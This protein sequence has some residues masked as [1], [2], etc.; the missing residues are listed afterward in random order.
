[1]SHPNRE[2][3]ERALE[4]LYEAGAKGI[5][6]A[7]VIAGLPVAPHPYATTL[8][9]GVGDHLDLLDHL[10]GARAKG[11][12]VERMASVDRTLLR[13]GTYELAFEPEQPE[14][15][16][17]SEFV[18]LAKRFSTDDSPKFVNGVLGSLAGDVRGGGP[19]R[20]VSCP[21]ALLIDMDGVIRHW[22]GGAAQFDDDA[23]GLPPGTIGA[24]ALDPDRVRR[25][26][27]GSITDAEWRDEVAAA[28]VANHGCDP[29]AAASAWRPDGFTFDH[30]V[31]RLV[32]SVREGGA[33]TA[34]VSNAS[35]RLEDDLAG[36]GVDDAFGV[37]VNSS[38]VRVMKP[39][40]G[41]YEAALAAVAAPA[42]DCLFVDDRPENVHGALAVGIPAIRFSTAARLEAT[43]R[44]VG[45]LT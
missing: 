9:E 12:T 29:D 19:W 21:L 1:M 17:I 4:L 24:I 32:R 15:I 30:E 11:W 14:G 7:T 28:L 43:L 23:L 42:G 45:L 38:N 10:I 22:T 44:R 16:V 2:G 40:R 35:S 25:A 27:D 8:A 31:L 6:P 36:H 37:V 3:R 13:L 20:N 26:N 5:H 41:I 34:C 33:L 18:E 39:A